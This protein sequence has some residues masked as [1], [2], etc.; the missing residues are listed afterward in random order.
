VNVL[1]ATGLNTKM[2][3]MVNLILYILPQLKSLR[4][5]IRKLGIVVHTH[6]PSSGEMEAGSSQTQGQSGLYSEILSPKTN[7]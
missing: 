5:P 4:I 7:K 2:V 1:N 6:N 3:K